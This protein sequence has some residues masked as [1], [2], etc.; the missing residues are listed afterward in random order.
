ME[1]RILENSS[2]YSA[3]SSAPS[4]TVPDFTS[5]PIRMK[6]FAISTAPPPKVLTVITLKHGRKGYIWKSCAVFLAHIP[7]HPKASC[8][9]CFAIAGIH[10]ISVGLNSSV[11]DSGIISAGGSAHL[12]LY[13]IRDERNLEKTTP[14]AF[15]LHMGNQRPRRMKWFAGIPQSLSE[16]KLA[17]GFLF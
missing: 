16:L 7:A 5:I 3:P 12:D 9:Y 8:T 6:V 2:S 1:A 10:E 4:S 13:G 14:S 15:I 17:S 11:L